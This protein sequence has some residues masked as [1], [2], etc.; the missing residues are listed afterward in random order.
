MAKKK[1]AGRSAKTASASQYQKQRAALLKAEINL[2]DHIE[3]VARLRRELPLV[4]VTKDYVFR[5]GPPDLS[6]NSPSSFFSANLSDLFAAGKDTLIVDHLMFGAKEEV[7][8][9][10]CS[11]WADGYNAVARHVGNKTNFVLVA[12]AEIGKLRDWARARNWHDLRVLSSQDNTFNR[13]FGFEEK[14][15]DQIPG[16]SVFRR[17]GDNIYHFYSQGA[18]LAPGRYRGIDLLSPVWNLFDTLPEGRE[19]WFP[20]HFYR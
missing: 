17:Q 5:E 19:Q 3:D 12:K 20:Q 11:M 15:G 6:I 7:A 4:R 10:M 8:C 2:L 16:I 1:T 18:E 13:D 9:P 14:N